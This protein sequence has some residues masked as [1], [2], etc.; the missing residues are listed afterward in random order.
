MPVQ[1]AVAEDVG[2]GSSRKPLGLGPIRRKHHS[3][4]AIKEQN[5]P[6]RTLIGLGRPCVDF[7]GLG[8]GRRGL[9][10]RGGLGPCGGLDRWALFYCQG[11]ADQG[12]VEVSGKDVRGDRS[13]RNVVELEAVELVF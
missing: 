11:V 8:L 7:H 13:P 9:G 2:F 5:S 3:N 12:L 10:G 6:V 4:E 1:L